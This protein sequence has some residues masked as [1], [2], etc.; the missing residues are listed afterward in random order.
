MIRMLGLALAGLLAL[1]QPLNAAGTV[2]GFSLTPQFDNLGK[3]MPGCRLYV[4][5]AGTTQTPQNS[6]QDTALTI[7]Q[8][9]PLVCDATGRLPQW[10]VA[11]GQIKVRLTNSAGI[12]QFVGDNLLV[13]GSSSG[14]GGGGGTVDPTTIAATGDVK[15]R[16]G[17]GVITGWVRQNGRTLGSATSGATER[18][19]ADCQALFEYIWNVD[20]YA[21]VS[22]GRGAS[23]NAD[24]VANKTIALP[25]ARNRAIA[26][27]GDMGNTDLALF[28]GSAFAF[29]NST[30]LGSKLGIGTPRTLGVQHLPPYTPTGAVSSSSSSSVSGGVFGGTGQSTLAITGGGNPSVVG[31]AAIAVSTST[32]STFFGNAQGGSSTPFDTVSPFILMTFYL[33]L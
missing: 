24:W 9:N 18:A 1:A 7:P 30:I 28:A 33:K 6:Y 4:I 10:F 32:T 3:V 21:A 13:I 17:Y 26:G 12:Q 19:N 5:Q 11:D 8:P 16:F 2:P 29:G 14:G 31:S 20:P 22:T 15:Y 25:D 23:A 27:L